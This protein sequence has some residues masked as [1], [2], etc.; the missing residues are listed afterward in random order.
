MTGLVITS[1]LNAVKLLERVDLKATLD[2]EPVQA[3]WTSSD[4][5]IFVVEPDSRALG[6]KLGTATLTATAAGLTASRMVRVVPD[7]TGRWA[8]LM[9]K[10]C[11]RISAE[12]PS[13][14]VASMKLPWTLRRERL[15]CLARSICSM[16]QP[17]DLSRES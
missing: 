10:T 2:A 6:V 13:H 8:G 11:E 15:E 3:S 17:S 14:A 5:S 1:P 16:S 7:Y 4:P 9:R 12:G